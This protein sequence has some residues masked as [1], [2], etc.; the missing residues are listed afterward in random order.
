[1]IEEA[2]SSSEGNLNNSDDACSQKS[3]N[4][5]SQPIKVLRGEEVSAMKRANEEQAEE[6]SCSVQLREKED[7]ARLNNV[8]TIFY[9]LNERF[10]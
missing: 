4:S 9:Q 1:M 2:N 6:I 10:E 5:S 8:R 3:S 7:R